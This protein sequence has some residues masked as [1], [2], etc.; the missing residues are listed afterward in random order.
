MRIHLLR[1]AEAEDRSPSGRDTDRRLTEAGERRMKA[2]AKA[3]ARLDLGIDLI[4]VSPLVRA[5]Q[6]AEPV[7]EACGYEGELVELEALVPGAEPEDV[8]HELARRKA[9][10]VLLVGHMPHLGSLLGRLVSGRD[11][12]DVAMKKASL[13]SFEASADPS[14]GRAELRFLLSPRVL[15][16]LS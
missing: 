13:A 1:H 10:S 2:V 15:E 14:S 11:D 16:A 12:L 9:S 8:L 4:L 5:R 7:A 6:T 3:I